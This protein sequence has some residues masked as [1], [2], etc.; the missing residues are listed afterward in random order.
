MAGA[1]ADPVDGALF[2]F[3]NS[4]KEV[5]GGLTCRYCACTHCAYP[6]VRIHMCIHLAVFVG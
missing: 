1:L 3:K 4:T 5:C 2:V 6:L